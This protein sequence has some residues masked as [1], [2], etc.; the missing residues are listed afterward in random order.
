MPYSVRVHTTIDDID[1]RWDDLMTAA[2]APVFYRRPFLRAFEKHPLH[3]VLRTA[4]LLIEDEAGQ[5]QAALPAYLQRDVDPMRVI[6][7]HYPHAVGRTVLL[8]HAWHCYDS[9]LPVR[10]GPGSR[11]AARRA[12]SALRE[13][14]ARWDARLC[15]IV[16]ADADGPLGTLLPDAGFTGVDI[17]VGWGL[18]LDD[19]DGFDDYLCNAL[20][21]KARSNLRHDL[22]EA[23]KAGVT[24]H[25]GDAKDA[26]LDTFVRLARA[27]AAKF[28]NS[29]YYRPGLFQDFVLALGDCAGSVELRVGDRTVA[30]ALTLTDDT[31]LHFWAVGYAQ[32]DTPGY[33]PF[34]VTYAHVMREAWASGREWVE[35][36]RRNPTFK[37]RYGLRP[38][39]LRGYFADVVPEGERLRG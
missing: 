33:S 37:R 7:D 10:P 29:D 2:R 31:R 32:K 18:T 21:R 4:Y 34:Y 16:N 6:A 15:G 3:P 24:A 39:A 38:R 11:S 36:G 28:D 13:V 25:T 17:D 14:A 35:L 23:D 19:Y 5:I 30:S 8:S 1:E 26:D 12:V 20:K 22:R 27:T 9:V